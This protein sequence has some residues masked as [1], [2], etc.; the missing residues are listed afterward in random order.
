MSCDTTTPEGM[1][2]RLDEIVDGYKE[3]GNTR[4]L[5]R[6]IGGSAE[7]FDEAFDPA[8]SGTHPDDIRN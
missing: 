2:K 1:A 8:S 6:L 5:V 3:S 7:D 4:A